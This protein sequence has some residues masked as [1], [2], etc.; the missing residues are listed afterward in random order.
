[1]SHAFFF[2]QSCLPKNYWSYVASYAIHLINRF[3]SNVFKGKTHYEIIYNQPPTYTNFKTFG[4]LYFASILESNCSKLES[5]S[6]ETVFISYKF[7]IKVMFYLTLR[8]DKFL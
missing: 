5:R 2:L 7:G 3:P 8:V 1:M 4:Y 6:R